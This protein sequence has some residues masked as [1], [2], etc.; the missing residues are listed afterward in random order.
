MPDDCSK[1]K[2]VE[3][4]G[5]RFFN[6][7]AV[8]MSRLA[9]C[10]DSVDLI[11][12]DPPYGIEGDSLDKHYN[13]NE[14]YVVEG[15]VDVPAQDYA[16]FSRAW[17]REAERVLRPGGSIYVVSGYTNLYHILDAL[18]DTSLQEINHIIWKYNFGVFT[19]RKYVSSHYH[20]LYY[21]KPGGER[22]FNL[23]SRYGLDERDDRGR[24]LNY[25]DREDVWLINR[26]YKPGEAKNR[27]EL[28][29]ELLMKLMQYSSDR[30]DLV[31]DFFLGGFSTAEVALGMDRD[32]VGFEI[33]EG[34]FAHG[35]EKISRIQRGSL[36]SSLRRPKSGEK[37]HNRGKPWSEEELDRL[38]R[39]FEGLLAEGYSKR[40]AVEMIG[41]ELGRGRFG[42]QYAL[43]RARPSRRD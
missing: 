13:R 22:V 28:P 31:C 40:D 15:Y 5:C 21:A 33:S 38:A 42:I 20:I 43:R 30:G 9:L 18:R 41:K 37:R 25:A 32:S 24:S 10:E 26:E 1:D 34:A 23:K 8:K 35:L 39:R 36:I 4:S 17:I 19:R 11:I 14:E 3:V 29:K 2:C 6:G 27:N 7:D 12:T 16:D